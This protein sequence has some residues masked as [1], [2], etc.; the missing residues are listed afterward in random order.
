MIISMISLLAD[1]INISCHMNNIFAGALSCADD[2]TLICPSIC[3][4]NNMIDICCEY[5]KEYDI[6]FNPTK[7]D[8]IKYG[9]KVQLY[10]HVVMN[11]N[12]IQWA[13]N[14][15]HL[16]NCVDVTLSD[17]LDYKYKRSMFI[18]YVN[19]LNSKFGH[20]LNL[21]NTYCCSF[22]D[23]LHGGCIRMVLI[24]M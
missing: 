11:G 6:K 19:Q 24:R 15:R 16:V 13:D 9:D 10:E 22:M 1:Y 18:G 14:V 2:F 7:T 3:G 4:I 5:A 23:P 17:S 8:C 12:T 20:L 21:F